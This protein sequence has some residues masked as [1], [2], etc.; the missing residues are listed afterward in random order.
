MFQIKQKSKLFNMI[1]EIN[2][3]KI[4]TMQII[5]INLM[6]E[7]VI[8]IKSGI[9][10]NVSANVKIQKN[11]VCEKDYISD[12]ATCSCKN[13]KYLESITVNLVITCDEI[14]EETKKYSNK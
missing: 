14:I 3:S 8:Q 1:T 7:S 5:N 11:C 12:S 6:V 4:L 9:T 10:I 2:E 13:Q